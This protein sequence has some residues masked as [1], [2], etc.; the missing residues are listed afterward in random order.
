MANKDD[1]L[2]VLLEG[3][4]PGTSVF[5]SDDVLNQL[6]PPG[7]TTLGWSSASDALAV[8]CASRHRCV[9][10]YLSDRGAGKFTRHSLV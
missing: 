5:V 9:F 7:L 1:G 6:F 10:V 3:L 2:A 4:E 8:A